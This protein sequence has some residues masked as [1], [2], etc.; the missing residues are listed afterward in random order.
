MAKRFAEMP[1]PKFV[2]SRLFFQEFPVTLKTFLKFGIENQSANQLNGAACLRLPSSAP[3]ALMLGDSAAA[4]ALRAAK[5]AAPWE[6][7]CGRNFLGLFKGSF[8][9]DEFDAFQ[10]FFG[11][12]WKILI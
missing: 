11:T 3:N 10:D 8:L 9:V 7:F 6:P 2:F 12:S 4:E 5:E 1:R